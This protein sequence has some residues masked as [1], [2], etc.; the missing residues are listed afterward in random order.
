[1]KGDPTLKQQGF[2]NFDMALFK[3]TAG[4]DTGK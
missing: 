1:M 4:N 2:K 3:N